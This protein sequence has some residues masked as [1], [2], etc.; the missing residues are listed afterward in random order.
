MHI[1]KTKIRHIKM[2]IYL[3]IQKDEG[4]ISIP[5]ALT[6]HFVIHLDDLNFPLI[7]PNLKSDHGQC[8]WPCHFSKLFGYVRANLLNLY[9]KSP[10]SLPWWW[11]GSWRKETT[12][13][14]DIPASTEWIPIWWDHIARLVGILCPSVCCLCCVGHMEVEASE[15]ESYMQHYLSN[16]T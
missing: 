10:C 16:D 12:S 7:F 15:Y 9:V 8:H 11:K 4:F 1:G 14:R 6:K 2:A 3:L 13:F 5:S